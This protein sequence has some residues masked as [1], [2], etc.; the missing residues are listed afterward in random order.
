MLRSD[1]TRAANVSA[2]HIHRKVLLEIRR[3]PWSLALGDTDAN[4]PKLANGPDVSEPTA[5]KIQLLLRMGVN[6][7]GLADGVRLFGMC[8]PPQRASN[9]P[10]VQ[11]PHCI[12]CIVGTVAMCCCS[13][14]SSI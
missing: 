13:A 1:V 8:T 11:P 10:T 7:H 12:G 2:A 5:R 14:P 4:I 9:R 3:L 6:K